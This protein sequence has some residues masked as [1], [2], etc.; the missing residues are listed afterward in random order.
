MKIQSAMLVFL[1]Q[2][3]ALLPCVWGGVRGSES[4]ADKLLPKSPFT[5]QFLDGILHC[6]L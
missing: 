3:F 5:G 4:Q 2:L 6:L 1:T